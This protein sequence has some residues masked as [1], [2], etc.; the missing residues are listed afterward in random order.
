MCGTDVCIDGNYLYKGVKGCYGVGG[1]RL[2]RKVLT[3]WTNRDDVAALGTRESQLCLAADW[4]QLASQQDSTPE[5]TPGRW[6][7]LEICMV[8]RE[9]GV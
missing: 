7:G 6:S 1:T 2:S 8:G 3:A 4:T 5:Q 9:S